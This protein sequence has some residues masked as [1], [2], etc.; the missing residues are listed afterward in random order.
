M[1]IASEEPLPIVARIGRR[2]WVLPLAALAAFAMLFISET[3]YWASRRSMD[4]ALELSI[5]RL[6]VQRVLRLVVDAESAE[7]GYLL[8]GRIDY[9]EPYR[10]AV[11]GLP[12]TFVKLREQY[13]S[14]ADRAQAMAG[15][16][17]LV[18][19]KL[20]ELS[21]AIR[22]YDEG[23]HEAWRAVLLSNIGTEQMDA[24][25][26]A[27]EVMLVEEAK[28][29]EEARK[30]VY[31][32]LSL[33][34]LGIA[35]LTAA[36][37]LALL[38]YLRKTRALEEQLR[39]VQL[40]VQAERDLLEKQV[41]LRTAD[42]TEL[43]R[44]L[45]TAREDE[46]SHLAREL[47]D[48]LGALLTAA[49]L[50]TARIKNRVAALSPEATERL[51]HLNETLNHGI[52]LKRRIIEDLIPSSLSNLGLVAALEILVREFNERSDVEVRCSL[53]PV[54]LRPAS[55]LT[56]YRLVQEALTNLSKYARATRCHVTLIQR[57]G[58]AEIAVE[59]DGVGFD[60]AAQTTSAH[61]LLGMRYR[62]EAEGGALILQS[63]PGGGSRIG[64]TLPLAATA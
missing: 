19:N 57:D 40:A 60:T 25:R 6:R 39:L 13:S 21:D 5:A 43:S 37:L 53:Q 7:R 54:A 10:N 12:E 31:R 11:E 46:R 18:A 16:E 35:A 62:V 42:L 17:Q 22:L 50:D 33:S 44:H 26:A 23:R 55:E 2:P 61:G 36:S 15:L 52:A 58:V 41:K 32:T 45:L 47:H 49:K 34:R 29:S 56:V 59:D 48:E 9:V 28:A 8:T 51:T 63:T 4:E 27:A 64:A 3:S 38:M 1:N 20:S 24:I 14:R 30:E